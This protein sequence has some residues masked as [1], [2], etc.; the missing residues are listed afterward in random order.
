M[1]GVYLIHFERPIGN[2]FE[3]KGQA[4]H[5]IG[6]AGDIA[7]RLRR[8]KSG[9]GAAIMRFV[10]LVGID[11]RCVRRWKD[12]TRDDERRLKNLKNA[13]RLCPICCQQRSRKGS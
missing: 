10:G 12:A 9:Q 4:Q 5:Y 1:R 13:P 8:H 11:W 3:R 7:R 2:T 6:W